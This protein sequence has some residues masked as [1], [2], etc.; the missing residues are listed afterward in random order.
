MPASYIKD[1]AESSEERGPE[2]EGSAAAASEQLLIAI[3]LWRTTYPG[4]W[5]E[6]EGQEGG[7]GEWREETVKGRG[8]KKETEQGGVKEGKGERRG[9]EGRVKA[10]EGSGE[11]QRGEVEKERDQWRD[12]SNSWDSVCFS[13]I[14]L[15]KVGS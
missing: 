14:W 3:L 13:V 8:Q 1:G 4:R 10:R 6:E 2:S 9:E 11:K 5:H 15:K 12:L 7:S